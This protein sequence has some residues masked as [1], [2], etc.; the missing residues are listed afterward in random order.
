MTTSPD[1]GVVELSPIQR[2]CGGA[3][4]A[5]IRIVGVGT[6]DAD[7]EGLGEGTGDA[8]ADDAGDG[9]SEGTAADAAG[10]MLGDGAGL[11]VGSASAAAAHIPAKT[12]GAVARTNP[13]RTRTRASV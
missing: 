7:A 1:F 2:I 11:G 6:G 8:L 5:S 3:S 9:V 13:I 4:G 10:V 12:I